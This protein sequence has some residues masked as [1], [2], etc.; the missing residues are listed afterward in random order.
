MHSIEIDKLTNGPNHCTRLAIDMDIYLNDFV[1]VAVTGVGDIYIESDFAAGGERV[2]TDP[3]VT[4]LEGGV[5]E[6][7]AERVERFSG[8]V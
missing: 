8:E 3:Q 5:A 2:A 4:V 1:A 6:T 7:V